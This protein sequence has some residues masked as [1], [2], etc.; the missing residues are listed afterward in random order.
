MAKVLDA[1]R[2]N[3][4]AVLDGWLQGIKGGIRRRDLIDERELKSQASE[5]LSTICAAPP[6]ASLEDLNIA[7][8]QPLKD[9]LASLSA[10]RA[11]QGFTPS[12]TS[13]PNPSRHS[14]FRAGAERFSL[15]RR[16]CSCLFCDEVSSPDSNPNSAA[17]SRAR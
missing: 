11:V 3:Q 12:E 2:K 15:C 6:D 8:W 5:V 1:V 9:L 16:G 14:R 4:E 7:A 10:S 17:I 13:G